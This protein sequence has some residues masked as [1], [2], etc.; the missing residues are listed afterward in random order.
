M[1]LEVTQEAIL[2]LKGKAVSLVYALV[3]LGC[4]FFAGFD[5]LGFA[6]AIGDGGGQV[7]LAAE[8]LLIGTLAGGVGLVIAALGSW[9]RRPGMSLIAFVSV[10]IVLPSAV[11]Y[12]WQSVRAFWINT[13]L[14]MHFGLWAWASAILPPFLGLVAAGLSWVRFR[15]LSSLVLSGTTAR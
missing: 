13:Q 4:A 15:R 6:F 7:S 10:L 5:T 3:L 9:T 14:G 12:G 11:L 8:T 2:T 1:F